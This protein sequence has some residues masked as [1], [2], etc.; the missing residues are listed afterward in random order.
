MKIGRKFEGFDPKLKILDSFLREFRSQ[1]CKIK[2]ARHQLY[3]D[4][5]K[6]WWKVRKKCSDGRSRLKDDD[7]WV[8][9]GDRLDGPSFDF[10]KLSRFP[11]LLFSFCFRSLFCISFSFCCLVVIS[12]GKNFL[13]GLLPFFNYVKKDDNRRISKNHAVILSLA[14]EVD[15]VVERILWSFMAEEAMDESENEINLEDQLE[16]RRIRNW[17]ALDTFLRLICISKTVIDDLVLRQ[18]IVV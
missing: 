3:E 10:G 4:V 16:Q 14:E 13:P 8:W 9:V 1:M 11:P 17:L 12:G 7:L 15:E 5:P 2:S 18:I 6:I